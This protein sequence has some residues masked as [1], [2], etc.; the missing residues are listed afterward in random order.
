VRDAG[1]WRWWTGVVAAGA[2]GAK[3]APRALHR[4]AAAA[5]GSSSAGTLGSAA[6][7]FLAACM[8]KNSGTGE[9]RRG[10]SVQGHLRP[11]RWEKMQKEK[12]NDK[13]AL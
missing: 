8:R 13:K 3:S 9:N 10:V 1:G 5:A 6:G 12:Q 2:W 11:S 4:A 7:F